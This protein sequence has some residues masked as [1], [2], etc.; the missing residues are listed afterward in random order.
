MLLDCVNF[1]Y[2][3]KFKKQRT[4]VRIYN[5]KSIN[6]EANQQQIQL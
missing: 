6:F 2:L 3:L 5:F 4:F 1:K